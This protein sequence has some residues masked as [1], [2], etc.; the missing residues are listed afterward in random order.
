MPTV[1]NVSTRFDKVDMAI[2]MILIVKLL[3]KH[4]FF[5][6]HGTFLLYYGSIFDQKPVEAYVQASCSRYFIKF[7][8][9]F[10]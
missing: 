10:G 4:R 6:L 7:V 9:F 2:N 3:S 1:L 5:Q 8:Y